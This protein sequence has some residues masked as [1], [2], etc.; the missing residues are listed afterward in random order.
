MGARRGTALRLNHSQPIQRVCK[1]PLLFA[2]LYKATPVHDSPEAHTE[3][4]KVLFRLREVTAEINK[5]THDPFT[6]NRIEK[7]WLLQDKLVFPNEVGCPQ[8]HLLR[9]DLG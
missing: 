3:L 9:T 8:V 2:A 6:R 4:E 1:Y 7:T 5:A